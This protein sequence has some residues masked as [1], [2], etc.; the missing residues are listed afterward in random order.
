MV[1]CVEGEFHESRDPR[2]QLSSAVAMEISKDCV[3]VMTSCGCTTEAVANFG[4]VLEK[5]FR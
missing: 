1:R 4:K 3:M 5:R 2:A